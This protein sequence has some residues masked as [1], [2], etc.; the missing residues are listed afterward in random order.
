MVSGFVLFYCSDP[1]YVYLLFSFPSLLCLLQS[2]VTCPHLINCSLFSRLQSNLATMFHFASSQQQKL[3]FNAEH[4]Y[5]EYCPVSNL[6]ICTWCCKN[7]ALLHVCW[8]DS[9]P[10]KETDSVFHLK[11][12]SCSPFCWIRQVQNITHLIPCLDALL[13]TD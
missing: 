8:S 2:T 9:A 4:Y 6:G 5:R 7:A 12:H 1:V 10:P 3:R 11:Q 13:C